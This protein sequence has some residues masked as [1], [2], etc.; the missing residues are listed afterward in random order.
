[1]LRTS[2]VPL[3]L[4]FLLLSPA[5]A[6][7]EPKKPAAPPPKP[8]T[9]EQAAEAV[10]KAVKA[11]DDTTLKALAVKDKPD[12]WLVADLLCYR[13]EPDAAE[14]FAK[15]APR[16]DTEK[17]PA[18]VETWRTREPDKAERE[19]LNAMN[20]AMGERQ[21]RRVI[22]D[23][24]LEWPL[25]TVIR[26]RLRH[27]RGLALRMAGRLQASA[28]VLGSGAN[29][30]LGLGWLRRASRMADE[31]GSAAYEGSAWEIAL[32]YWTPKLALDARRGSKAG[33]AGTL[34]SFGNVYLSLGDYAKALSTYERAREQLQALGDMAG[35]AR[36]LGNIGNV[37]RSLGDFVGALAIY[38][39]T[40]AQLE[41]LGDKRGVA[42]TLGNI[43]GV[44]GDLGDYP[45]ALESHQRA[46]AQMHFLGDKA[47]ASKALG[48]IGIIHHKLGDYAKALSTFEQALE[49]MQ[50]LGDRS[51]AAELL[52][53]IG[54]V[55]AELGDYA[56]AR[57]SYERS[58]SAAR[59]LRAKPLLIAALR[60]V[61]RLHLEA[62]KPSRAIAAAHQ[63]VSEVESLLGG[64]GEEHGATARAQY[65]LLFGIGALAAV[66]EGDVAEVFTFLE[67]GR[68]GALLDSLD[69]RQA[70]RW[71][72]QSLSPELRRLDL[73]AR[74]A[75]REARN[76]YDLALERGTRKDA[77]T[78]AE[79]LDKASEAVL[80]IAGR[81]QRELKQQAGLF[82]P[83]VKSLY[84]IQDALEKDQALVLYGLCL[85]EALALVLR[86]DG[87]RIVSLGKVVD[88]EAACAVLEA[89][90]SD[91]ELA[92]ALASLKAML[93]D[94]LKLADDVKHVLVSPEGPLCYLPLGALFAQT[95]TMTPSGTTH[96]L[97]LSEERARGAGILALGAPDY[98]GISEGAKSI[99]YRGRKL[100]P[101]P[102]TR[103]E[104]ETIGTYTLL[105]E[106]ASEAGLRH[107]LPS[108]KRWRAVHF[109]CHGLVDV[110]RPMLSSLALSRTGED[111]GF[112]TA[113]EILRMRVP[114]DLAVLS[115]SDTARGKIVKGEGIVGLT[116][117][118]MF[119]GAPRV[120]CSLW[121]V[122]DEA[123][124]A[125]MIKFYELWNPKEGKGLG[126]AEALQKAQA[127]VR[128]YRDESG[129]QKWKHPYYW[130]AWVLWGL[131]R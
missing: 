18:Y 1:M 129:K 6:E 72:E 91:V 82:Y 121:K 119:A 5:A 3:L 108:A 8:L 127:Y 65:A 115:G 35:A 105:G 87:E 55:Q 95:V 67:S 16:V 73:E 93:V 17:L 60:G 49:Q 9:T 62:N 78:A 38:M 69:K 54:D 97:L 112:L 63:A 100:S 61:A 131:P 114:A 34:L 56:N 37:N 12:P 13:G 53:L 27:T 110:E 76:S 98:S 28:E 124:Q 80:A 11:K 51:G 117:A 109:A 31:A 84:D 43:S 57:R 126:A 42:R 44:Y 96:A 113:L 40:L 14:A 10:L 20:A 45:K 75:E 26:I 130:A 24:A 94:P 41:A 4:L 104:V 23:T 107:A 99:Y 70:L 64:L 101:L 81:I 36:A 123:T 116:R 89:S 88:V 25:D 83:R 58:V 102:A 71:K 68:A 103:K 7:E 106:K 66:R 15:A 77:R 92:K 85:D 46:L 111:D 39:R 50:A 22:S 86:Q 48:N 120:I 32:L 74:T 47:A 52:G 125:L 90:D 19:L 118:F 33:A 128:E 59:S 30:A 21:P 122:D 2:V 29:A 79:V